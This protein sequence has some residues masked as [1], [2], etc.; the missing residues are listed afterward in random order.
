MLEIQKVS[1]TFARGTVNERVGLDN[2][3]LR[4]EAGEFAAVIGSNG[5]GK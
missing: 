2:V 4:L 3:S 1:K 5:A